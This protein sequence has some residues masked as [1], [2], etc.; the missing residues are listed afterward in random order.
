M[1]FTGILI[2][3][4][5]ATIMLSACS[6]DSNLATVGNK[7]IS[8]SEFDAY[9]KF[10][11]I[12]TK[13]EKRKAAVLDQYLE[14]EALAEAI[15]NGDVLDAKLIEAELNEFRKEMLISRYFEKYLK[16]QVTDE[17]TKIF[18][19]ANAKD[20]EIKK[21]QV[22]H[23]LVRTRPDMDEAERKSKLTTLQEAYSKI[24]SGKEFAEIASTYSEDKISAKKGGDL[25]WLKEGAIDAKFSEVAFALK[26]GEVSDPFETPFGF[27]VVKLIS[28]PKV[29]KRPFDAVKGN[30][31]YQLRN[32]AKA[33]ELKRLTASV[34]I[35]KND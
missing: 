19:A 9:M 5:A 3:S 18:Y 25:G 26:A 11:R 8:A 24:K 7:K 14:R 13:D 30:I 1:K 23:I 21:V 31:R 12:P 20:Y 2:T 35:S 27:H 16:E 29:I 28:E 10:K 33:A 22:A 4:L 32:M 6:N 15:L 17:S 34:K